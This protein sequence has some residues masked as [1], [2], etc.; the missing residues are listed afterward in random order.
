MLDRK[1]RKKKEVV[2]LDT[3]N[4][5]LALCDPMCVWNRATPR[6]KSRLPPEIPA[7]GI[8]RWGWTRCTVYAFRGAEF[9]VEF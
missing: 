6:G 3:V 5:R 9:R 7:P 2:T 4:E 8:H 1:K